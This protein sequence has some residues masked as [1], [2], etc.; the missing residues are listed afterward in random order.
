MKGGIKRDAL[1]RNPTHVSSGTGNTYVLTFPQSPETYYSGLYWFTADKTNT[2]P[3]TLNINGLGSKAIL[4]AAGAALE[5]GQIVSGSC[6]CLAYVGASF[7]MQFTHANPTFTGDLTATTFTGN[8]A[9]LT[10]LN[11]TN[12]TT[13]TVNNARLPASQTGKTFTSATTVSAGGLTVGGGITNTGSLVM[14]TNGTTLSIQRNNAN[15]VDIEAFLTTNSATKHGLD[16]NRYGG[17]VTVGGSRV[18]TVY[19]YGAGRGLDADKLDGQEGAYYLART[20]GTG[21]QPISTVSGLQAAIDA[22][23]ASISAST[24]T[25]S[26]TTWTTATAPSGFLIC[27]GSAVS[28]TTYA[29]LFAV[30]GTAYGAGNGTSTFNIPDL[31]GVFVRGLD[32][33]RGLDS[34]R[35][36]GSYQDS[37]NKSHSHGVNDPGHVHGGVQNGQS[38]TGRST[39]VDQPP[40]VFSFGNTWGATTG[41]WLSASGGAESRPRNV[42]LN[43][44]IKT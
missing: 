7:R 30:I 14:N 21:T 19:D 31:R 37:D 41:I 35:G 17:L 42:A 27:N 43:Y 5:A 24:P 15:A 40:A 3:A 18:V 4:N 2:G 32:N 22:L 6:V 8:G 39:S 38:S 9:A 23:N 26:I 25:G 28:R 16:L 34:G 33:G 1:L 13:G 29:A 12:L 10:A 44:I 36:L 11:A 20:N